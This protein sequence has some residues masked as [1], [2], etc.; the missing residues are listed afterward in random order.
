M[1]MRIPW[2]TAEYERVC[3]DCGQAWRVPWAAAWRRGRRV[4][5]PPDALGPTLRDGR[6]AAAR[7][8][9]CVGRPTRLR[10]EVAPVL[11]PIKLLTE[12]VSAN[13]ARAFGHYPRKGVLAPGSDADLLIWDSKAETTIAA[14]TFDD[15]TGD[16]V[17][18]GE[19]LSGR[20]RDVLL[21]G[22]A[23]VRDGRYVAER[24]GGPYLSR[25]TT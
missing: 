8:T 2:I 1:K 14:D 19:R 10:A 24:A 9:A 20:V 5:A 12:A 17:Y 13:P 16:Y 15:G 25:G 11:A 4:T 22:R 3:R 18:L 7:G 6:A 23:L 21:G